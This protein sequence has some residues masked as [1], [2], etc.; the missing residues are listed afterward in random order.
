MRLKSS[1][2]IFTLI[3]ITGCGNRYGFNFK[4]DWDWK[5]LRNHTSDSEVLSNID[6]L[7]KNISIEEAKFLFNELSSLKKPSDITQLSGIEEKQNQSGGGYYGYISLSFKNPEQIPIPE[8]FNSIIACA[9]FLANIHRKISGTIARSNIKH[10]SKFS[11]QKLTAG[12]KKKVLTGIQID[13]NTDAVMNVLTHYINRDI[14]TETAVELAKH[15]TF[16]Q[17]LINRREIGYIPEPLPDTDD[18][19]DFIYTAGRSD[20][21]FMIWKWLNPWNCFGFADLY[22]NSAKY[23]E[24]LSEINSNKEY[25]V[26]DIESRI[27]PYLPEDFK[28]HDQIDL[29]VNWGILN[30]STEKQSGINI[31]HLKNDYSTFKRIASRQLFR[32]IIVYLIK[33]K[34]NISPDQVVEINKIIAGNYQNIYDQLFQEVLFQIFLEGTSAYV[35]GKDKSWII[36]DGYKFGKDLLNSIYFS[37]YENVDLKTME[38]CESQGFSPNGPLVAIGYQMTKVLVKKYGHQIIYNTLEDNFLEF[39]IKYLEIEQNYGKRK[40]KIFNTDIAEKIYQL[41]SL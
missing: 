15:P 30:W 22:M 38:Y 12:S 20:P 25:L 4:S 37:L 3:C 32:K 35:A 8:D 41:N 39:F 33:E 27:A 9:N 28:Y 40:I 6:N 11:N 31:V 1:L 36:A 14:S 26:T 17:M 5:A 23:Y 13:I 16:E 10:N 7:E 19:A 2:I 21:V 34:N 18:L 29:G 24:I